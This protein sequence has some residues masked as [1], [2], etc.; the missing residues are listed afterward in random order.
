MGFVSRGRFHAALFVL[1]IFAALSTGCGSGKK[2]GSPSPSP[3]VGPQSPGSVRL[4]VQWPSRTGRGAPLASESLVVVF[5]DGGHHE[6]GRATAL[7]GGGNDASI[8]EVRFTNIPVGG[9]F[10]TATAYPQVDGSGVAQARAEF[11]ITVSSGTETVQDLSPQS[12]ITTIAI[13]PPPASVTSSGFA[14]VGVGQN[15]ALQPVARDASGAIVLTNPAQFVWQSSDA[16]IATVNTVGVVA[17]VSL[18][19]AT[20]TVRDT[21]SGVTAQVVVTN[22]PPFTLGG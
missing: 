9:Y 13:E 14:S 12:T 17:G 6:L 18:G 21:E 11:P 4:S 19:E 3:T 1:V 16:A 2:G 5:A 8:S 7:R 10:V 15:L 22:G 20:V